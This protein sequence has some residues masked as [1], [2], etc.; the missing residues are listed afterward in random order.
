MRRMG[1][2]LGQENVPAM[3]AQCRAGTS[4]DIARL[5]QE[6]SFSLAT[7]MS[8]DGISSVDRMGFRAFLKRLLTGCEVPMGTERGWLYR[9]IFSV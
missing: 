5:L 9:Y 7:A 3:L 1:N 8:G 6:K 4:R 2:L